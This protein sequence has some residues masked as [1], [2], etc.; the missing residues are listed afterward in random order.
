[1]VISV[2]T[3]LLWIA[4]TRALSAEMNISDAEGDSTI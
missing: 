3:A 2:E 1:M 4:E